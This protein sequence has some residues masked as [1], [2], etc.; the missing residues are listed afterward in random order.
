MSLYA[1]SDVMSVAVPPD[2][3][4]CGVTHSRP[5]HQG[6]PVRLWEL[7]CP[8][9]EVFLRD[10]DL[11]HDINKPD[12]HSPRNANM[13]PHVVGNWADA[14]TKIPLT[15]DELEV[16]EQLEA[17]GTREMA[18]NAQRVA[19]ESLEAA[20]VKNAREQEEY[21]RE[22]ERQRHASEMRLLQA[23]M[24]E[25]R[26]MLKAQQQ[27]PFVSSAPN[28]TT[29][30]TVVGVE[31]TKSPLKGEKAERAETLTPVQPG[32]MGICIICGG[33]AKHPGAKGPA[34]KTCPAC[35]DKKPKG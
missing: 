4:G 23:E 25:L 34:P 8:A 14:A 18:Q 13:P 31:W 30:G 35:R 32:K 9:C 15:P 2:A 22:A 33:P 19:S 11:A 1:R 20:K 27:V 5:V 28:T 17:Q 6:A 16:A 12:K 10:T 26:A 3:G 7:K 21:A 24:S 29:T